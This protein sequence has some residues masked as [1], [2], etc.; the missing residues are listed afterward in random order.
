[1]FCIALYMCVCEQR[2]FSIN[3]IDKF[4]LVEQMLRG[5]EGFSLKYIKVTEFIFNAEIDAMMF[6]CEIVAASVLP[7]L[8]RMCV[9]ILF[10]FC[11][12]ANGEETSED[13]FIEKKTHFP[14]SF[15]WLWRLN[16]ILDFSCE[17]PFD[18]T[19]FGR[20]IVLWLKN[21]AS[22]CCF[23]DSKTKGDEEKSDLSLQISLCFSSWIRE[24]GARKNRPNKKREISKQN[25]HWSDFNEYN[26]RWNGR[27][28]ASKRQ[29]L[30]TRWNFPKPRK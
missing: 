13:L 17:I 19:G 16:V 2:L 10:F 3:S 30:V 23:F 14:Y 26:S 11:W 27:I 6:E 5:N 28:E 4:C 9:S 12:K 25:T 1:M 22:K 15:N 20:W 8:E 29:T 7:I 18:I 24:R 21:V